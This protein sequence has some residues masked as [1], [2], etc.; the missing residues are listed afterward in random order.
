MHSVSSCR[1][2]AVAVAVA[3]P[4]EE[5]QEGSSGRGAGSLKRSAESLATA[6]ESLP[7]QAPPLKELEFL[8]R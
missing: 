2:G 1:V 6:Q 5:G 8:K 3:R 4:V 7:Q